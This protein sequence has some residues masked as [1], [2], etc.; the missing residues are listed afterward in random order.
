M[1]ALKPRFSRDSLV[2]KTARGWE[3][4]IAAGGTRAYRLAQLDDQAGLPRSQYLWHPPLTLI[5][6]ARVSEHPAPGTWGFG[7]WNDPYGFTFGPGERFLRFPALPQAAWFFCAS[8]RCYLSFRDDKPARGFYAQ[9]LR[10]SGFDFSLVG[11]G[12][13]LPF[14]PR[15]ARRLLSNII[16]EDAA[17]VTSDPTDW[18]SYSLEWL[19]AAT[20]FLVDNTVLMQSRVAPTAPLGL[21]LWI[22]N[23]YA[24]FDPQGRIRWG[25]EQNPNEVWLEIADLQIRS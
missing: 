14:S 2:A 6:R 18:H 22:D 19:P 4:H 9:S 24:A 15:R 10:G 11:A 12:L 16:G 13:V 25:V 8:P 21:V 3:L 20:T 5:L 1:I 17:T 7:L 23:Q